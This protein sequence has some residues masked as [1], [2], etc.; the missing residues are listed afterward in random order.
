M[1][2]ATWKV[3]ER[4]ILAWLGS[5]RKPVS[6][7]QR[8]KDG[9]DGEHPLFHV[10]Q[11]HSKRHALLNVW[12]GAKRQCLKSKKVPIVTLSSP[13]RPG[14]WVLMKEEDLPSLIAW[15]MERQAPVEEP[16]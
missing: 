2:E 7:R 1:P 14:F 8:D 5:T 12:D 15:F 11:K 3:R 9:D 6:G 4:K 16:A 13:H 10:Q